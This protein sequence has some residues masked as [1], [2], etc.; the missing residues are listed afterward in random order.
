MSY[1]SV[2]SLSSDFLLHRF[3]WKHSL[4]VLNLTVICPPFSRR[5]AIRSCL[6][7]SRYLSI[8]ERQTRQSP[9]PKSFRY[10]SHTFGIVTT[11]FFTLISTWFF[12]KA[13][14]ANMKARKNHSWS[15]MIIEFIWEFGALTYRPEFDVPMFHIEKLEHE[16]DSPLSRCSAIWEE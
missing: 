9:I 15:I 3:A 1:S 5:L 4:G 16:R 7:S 6:L 14:D 12:R 13:E 8:W 2:E 11:L 10:T